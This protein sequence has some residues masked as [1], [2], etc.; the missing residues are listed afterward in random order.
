MAV[1]FKA[2]QAEFAGYI[3][4]PQAQPMPSDVDPKRMAMYRELFFNNVNSFLSSNFP[5]LRKILDDTQWQALAQD[6]FLNHRCQTPHFSEIAE[7]FLEYLQNERQ[8]E[9]D[10]PFLLELAHYEW[11]EMAL[12]ISQ[13]NPV[14]GDAA[15]TDNILES[16]LSLSPVAWPLVYQFPVEKIGPD[17][18]P[19]AAPA[20]PSYLVVYRDRE[21][22]VN[23][24][25]TTPVTFRLLQLI[26]EQDKVLGARSLHAL[27]AEF[28]QQIDPQTLM[29]FGLETLQTLAE[30]GI[31]IPAV[32]A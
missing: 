3:R 27:A 5:V 13:A 6:F 1:D 10:F 32:D 26:E 16:R 7:E 23:F 12:S 31:L 2:K 24:M 22:E 29:Q 4:N 14:F 20:Q 8:A 15:F 17:Y 28:S 9:G 19:I 18:L 11:V 30:K 21:D 25:Q